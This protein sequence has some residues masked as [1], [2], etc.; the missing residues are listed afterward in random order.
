MNPDDLLLNGF[1]VLGTFSTRKDAF[2]NT[3]QPD[4][5]WPLYEVKGHIGAMR[6]QIVYTFLFGMG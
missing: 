6:G 3:L 4:L 1:H 2:W 5:K